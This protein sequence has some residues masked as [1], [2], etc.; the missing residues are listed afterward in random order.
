MLSPLL[1]L[2]TFLPPPVAT[3]LQSAPA[4]TDAAAEDGWRN[5][6]GPTG[7]GTAL[8]GDPPTKWSEERNIRWKVALP[9]LGSSSPVIL[10]DCVYLTSAVKTERVGDSAGGGEEPERDE[11]RRGSR[12]G[13]G[14]SPP[15]NIH[16]FVV[17]S[18]D[19]LT[20]EELWRTTVS[21][22]VPHEAIHSTASQASNSPVTDGKH[23]F[24]FFGSRGMHCLDLEGKIIWSKDFGRMRTRNQFGEGSSPALHGET[25]VIPWDHEGDSFLVALD[26]KSGDEKWRRER[27]E[28]SNWTTPRIVEVQ[29]KAQVIVPGTSASIAYDLESGETIWSCTGMTGN[30]IPTPVYEDGVVYLMSGFRGAALQ[31]IRLEGAKGNLD[32]SENLLWTHDDDTSYTPSALLHGGRLYFVRTNSGVLSCLDAKSGDVHYEGQRLDGLRTVYSSPVGIADRIYVISR[33][34][35]T[36]VIA[37][38]DEYRVLAT[39]EL[40]DGFDASPA[41][42]GDAIYLRGMKS[43]YCIA[44]VEEED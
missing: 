21:E 36:A 27:D 4:E 29:G 22:G 30:V 33:G 13:H 18:Y 2:L 23:V 31:A 35:T 12:R 28:A 25:L 39:N 26:K 7:N 42:V 19:R 38:G 40:D 43:L 34:G 14:S 15:V 3:P 10:G 20:G 6:R 41:I 24:A 16:E 1:A 37:A 44:E 11:R 8:S 32:E 9:G 17:L 5:W